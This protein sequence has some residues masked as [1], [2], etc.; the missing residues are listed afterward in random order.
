M[1]TSGW[2]APWNGRDDQAYL[3]RYEQSR[4][5]VTKSADIFQ[6]GY[7][8]D[9]VRGTVN[10]AGFGYIESAQRWDTQLS[11]E[12]KVDYYDEDLYRDMLKDFITMVD[13]CDI[14]CQQKG[15]GLSVV[16]ALLAIPYA[17][18]GLTGIMMLL[19]N[20][21]AGCRVGAIFCTI[22][23]GCV[24]FIML[25]VS[26]TMLFSNYSAVC[27]K[28]MTKTAGDGLFW[29]MADDFRMV[30]TLWATSWIWLMCFCCCGCANTVQATK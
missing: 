7:R 11:V 27:M 9:L 12:G 13:D 17:M 24:L 6:A 14:D 20:V 29:H 15:S 4:P 2:W 19:G 18:F 3:P 21:T 26:A 23:S 1:P 8:E 25:L 30:V 22:C 5:A 28:S 16:S 10:N